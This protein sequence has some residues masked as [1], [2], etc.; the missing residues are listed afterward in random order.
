MAKHYA[1]TWI[2][3]GIKRSLTIYLECDVQAGCA[4]LRWAGRDGSDDGTAEVYRL[5]PTEEIPLGTVIL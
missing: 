5:T 3:D 2:K 4:A 1:V